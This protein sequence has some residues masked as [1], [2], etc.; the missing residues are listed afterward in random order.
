M[1]DV[2]GASD[3]ELF[4]A[5]LA[6]EAARRR[7]DA[8]QAR[9]LAELERR[10]ACD[11]EFGQATGS[12]L[13]ARTDLPVGQCRYR[14]KVAAKLRAHLPEVLGALD[15]G[16]ISWDH[17]RVIHEAANP[18]IID[19]IAELQQPIIEAA[20]GLVFARWAGQVRALAELLDQDGGHDPRR[21][22]AVELYT[23]PTIGGLTLLFGSL[24]DDLTPTVVT[25]LE[26]ITDQLFRQASRD[27]DATPELPIPSRA[28]LRARALAEICRRSGARDR[29]DTAPPRPEVVVLIDAES[30]DATTPDGAKV[31]PDTLRGLVPSAVW[32][33]MWLDEQRIP[34]DLGR[35]QR[36]VSPHQRLALGVRDGGCAFPGCDAPAHWCDGHH[37][38]EWTADLGPTDLENLALL[39]RHHHGVTHRS[40]WS[41]RADPERSGAFTWTTP[42]GRTLH[43]Q[44]QGQQ[45]RAPERWHPDRPGADRP[46]PERPLVPS[47]A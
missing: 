44:R 27:H 36:T 21:D 6:G 33:A 25:E 34:L 24:S 43:S 41:M 23:S 46:E 35:S 16:R 2:D 31:R 30:G 4:R 42:Q 15:D 1:F 5:A 14:V 28:E 32:R 11:L 38:D 40:G 18:R 12:W 37:V 45:R 19:A 20:Q 7:H 29:A 10:G 13:A 17:V 9:L 8:E 22:Q 47:G 39:C 3:E 26:R